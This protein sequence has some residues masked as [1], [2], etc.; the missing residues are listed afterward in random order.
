MNSSGNNNVKNKT[1]NKQLQIPHP[2]QRRLSRC[3]SALFGAT[4]ASASSL[5]LSLGLGELSSDSYL[6]QPLNASIELVSLEG[7]ID[8]NTL[9]VRQVTPDEASRM[10][11][12][13][14]YMP[15]RINF[16]VATELGAPAGVRNLS[17]A[18]Q[19]AV[20]EYHG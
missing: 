6:G 18:H 13:V 7:D 11:V 2:Q 14:L 12:D 8:L 10:G 19:R 3:I 5:A 4:L 16:V 1:Q 17:R 15:Y 9:I 20:S